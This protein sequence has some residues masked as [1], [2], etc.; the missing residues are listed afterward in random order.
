MHF[1]VFLGI[2]RQGFRDLLIPGSNLYFMVL[3]M[4]SGNKAMFAEQGIKLILITIGIALGFIIID[5]I[6][7]IIRIYL[8]KKSGIRD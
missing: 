5:V 6:E 2:P 8:V 3:G 1:Y 7:K 4:I